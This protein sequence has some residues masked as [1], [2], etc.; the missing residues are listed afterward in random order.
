MRRFNFAAPG[1]IKKLI[2]YDFC[3]CPPPRP[4]QVRKIYPIKSKKK[5]KKIVWD[6]NTEKSVFMLKTV[7]LV[8]MQYEFM[9]LFWG[10]CLGYIKMIKIQMRSKFFKKN[11]HPILPCKI[12]KTARGDL[13]SRIRRVTSKL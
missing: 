11:C 5:S 9:S 1:T 2:Y 6:K 7:C 12:L 8:F 3:P 10:C 4:H 13:I